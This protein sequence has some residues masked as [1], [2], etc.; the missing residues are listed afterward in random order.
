MKIIKKSHNGNFFE[1]YRKIKYKVVEVAF[2][3]FEI[4]FN[5]KKI[6]TVFRKLN[7][8][9]AWQYRKSTVNCKYWIIKVKTVEK[10][11]VKIVFVTKL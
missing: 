3:I 7:T 2:N 6:K 1:T 5:W 10:D 8:I 4:G 11:P 9:I